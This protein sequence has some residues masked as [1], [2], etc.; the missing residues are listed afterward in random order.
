MIRS[1]ENQGLKFSD[2]PADKAKR[3]ITNLGMFA[4][5]LLSISS[6]NALAN[7]PAMAEEGGEVN[8]TEMNNE[9]EQHA[10]GNRPNIEADTDLESPSAVEIMM[11]QQGQKRYQT[12]NIMQLPAK[13]LQAGET[14]KIQLLDYPRRGMSMQKV[15]QEYGQP[16]ATSESV[17]KPPIT[18]WT[19]SDRIVYFE[20]STVIHVVA[21]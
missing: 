6:S 14:V 15:Q 21:R 3:D 16:I 18:H 7:R 8:R 4:A 20:H 19:Y 17:G 2:A 10:S 9:V 13:E 12:G 5:V 1:A 11:Q